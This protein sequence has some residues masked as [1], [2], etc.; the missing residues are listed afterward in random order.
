MAPT[1]AVW[2]PLSGVSDFYVRN[3]LEGYNILLNAVMG[4]LTTIMG[5]AGVVALVV[6]K[7]FKLPKWPFTKERWNPKPDV[8]K[9]EKKDEVTEDDI[10][11]D[12]LAQVAGGLVKR[13]GLDEIVDKVKNKTEK[14][15]EHGKSG[16]E[17]IKEDLGEIVHEAEE[18]GK[19]IWEDIEEIFDNGEHEMNR[20]K[21]DGTK[22]NASARATRHRRACNYVS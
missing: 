17:E 15:I 2:N 16:F 1:P 13:D 6:E 20:T 7:G 8:D 5:F 10:L 11:D 4:G 22:G 12:E 18:V 19:E 21:A 3:G 14:A 9:D